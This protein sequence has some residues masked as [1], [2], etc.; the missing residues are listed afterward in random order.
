M[1]TFNAVRDTMRDLNCPVW[2]VKG[3]SGTL[4]G[5][6]QDPSLD[7]ELSI[8]RMHKLLGEVKGDAVRVE[9]Q[10]NP[11]KGSAK[12]GGNTLHILKMDVDLSTVNPS[13]SGSGMA[14]IPAQPAGD[15]SRFEAM[16]QK[17]MDQNA[18]LQSQLIKTK[19]EQQIQA[20]EQKIE[21]ISN[22]QPDDPIGKVI[23]MMIPILAQ[24]L[25]SMMQKSGQSPVINGIDADPVA[26]LLQADPEGM[27]VIEA[28][29]KLAE[30][31]PEIY[32]QYKPLLLQM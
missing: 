28:I 27:I 30:H 24:A 9:L 15:F 13:G 18:E 8:Q 20:L 19:Y 14:G 4:I 2:K 11:P 6:Q 3:R 7:V 22:Q 16:L 23:D 26:R 21:G 10:P 12:K 29:A 1:T 31:K 32:Q 5:Y 25:P 17:L